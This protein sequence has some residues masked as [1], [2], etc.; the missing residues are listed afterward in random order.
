[1]TISCR[2]RLT[3][4]LTLLIVNP[5]QA[6]EETTTG[7][8]PKVPG[9]DP[10]AIDDSQEQQKPGT[11]QNE[12]KPQAENLKNRDLGAAFRSFRPSEEISADNAVPFPV[13][14]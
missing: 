4:L 8:E 9:T 14:I 13:D 1:M 2:I 3:C 12:Q 10:A 7:S 6:Q 11:E 5:L